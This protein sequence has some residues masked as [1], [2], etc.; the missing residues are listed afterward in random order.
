MSHIENHVTE[1]A[2]TAD[3][4]NLLLKRIAAGTA[5]LTLLSFVGLCLAFGEVTSLI[6]WNSV[7]IG[8]TASFAAVLVAGIVHQV[9]KNLPKTS[10]PS[11]NKVDALPSN[12]AANLAA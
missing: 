2:K 8:A 10:H 5:T 3:R 6:A 9:R 12:G 4:D 11:A 7:L 1:T